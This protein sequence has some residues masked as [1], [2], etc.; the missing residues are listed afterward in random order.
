M[1]LKDN[2]KMFE[3]S[4]KRTEWCCLCRQ[5]ALVEEQICRSFYKV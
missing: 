4:N 2:S 3:P 1:D 5:G